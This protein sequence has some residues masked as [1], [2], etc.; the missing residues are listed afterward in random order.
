MT[1]ISA[2]IDPI[3]VKNVGRGALE[4]AEAGVKVKDNDLGLMT[5]TG[6]NF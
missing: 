4:C 5:S 1:A 6:E 3:P 2:E